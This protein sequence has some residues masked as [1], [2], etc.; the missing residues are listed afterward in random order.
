MDV[1]KPRDLKET[2]RMRTTFAFLLSL[3]VTSIAFGQE[4]VGAPPNRP[5]TGGEPHVYY[6]HSYFKDHPN[7]AGLGDL[8]SVHVQNFSTL[9]KQVDGNCSAIV[10]FMN[11]MSLQGLKAESCEAVQGHVRFRLV[12]T[13]EADPV[14]HELL[15]SPNGFTRRVSIS[16]GKDPQFSVSSSVT[17]FELEVIPKMPFYVFIVLLTGSLILFIHLCRSS[18]L[19]RNN[20]PGVPVEKQSYS[21][22]LFQMAFWFFLVIAAYVF[23]WLINDELDTIT[24]SVLGLIGIGAATAIGATLVDKNKASMDAATP[25]TRGFI[26]D[27]LSD[28]SG[29]T[30]HRFQMFVWTLVLGVIFVASVFRSLEMPEFS[31]G[32]LGLMGISSGTY[33]G[34]KVQENAAPA[35]TPTSGPPPPPQP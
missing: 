35:A 28:E 8:L 10:L 31:A 25:T 22:A 11:G 32:L 9:L 5:D 7:R 6:A 12:R 23:I 18:S 27:V 17:D 30:L 13:P 26:R 29:I 14:W 4:P 21:L 2:L 34:F 1:Q 33:V 24:D 16:V 19:I 20:V 15:G 3:L